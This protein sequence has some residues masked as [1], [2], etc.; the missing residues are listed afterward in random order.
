MSIVG[1][2]V[3]KEYLSAVGITTTG[4]S[5]SALSQLEDQAASQVEGF[6]GRI[7][8]QANYDEFFDVEDAEDTLFLRN[9]PIQ[10]VAAL[11]ND[12]TL[13]SAGEMEIYPN[14]GMIKLADT[15]IRDRRGNPSPFFVEGK[16]TVVV[17][18]NAGYTTIP[19]EIGSVVKNLVA[20]TLGGAGSSGLSGESIGN[21]RYTRNTQGDGTTGGFTSDELKILNRYRPRYMYF[22]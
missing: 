2:T 18:Y 15:L 14:E 3:L 21:Y 19:A 13:V 10:S 5:D 1:L 12:G 20:R 9:F 17:T 6:T 4:I 22:E 8:S 16:R 7:F 11:T